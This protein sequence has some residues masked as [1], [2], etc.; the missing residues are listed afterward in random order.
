MVSSVLWISEQEERLLISVHSLGYGELRDV[1]VEHSSERK[2]SRECR[3]KEVNLINLVRSGVQYFDRIV[4][5]QNEPQYAEVDVQIGT[6]KG[7]KRHK[8]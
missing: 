1:L 3:Q 8:F 6:F 2:K 4:V 5:H 7:T